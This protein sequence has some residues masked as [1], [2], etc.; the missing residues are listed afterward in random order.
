MNFTY[1]NQKNKLSTY[2]HVT[3]WCVL[4]FFLANFG[5]SEPVP[6]NTLLPGQST[7]TMIISGLGTTVPGGSP[8]PGTQYSY[9]TGESIF[10]MAN[11]TSN[12]WAFD[13]WS[14]DIGTWN[15]TDQFIRGLVM[16]QDRTVT[17]YFV[18]ADWTMTIQLSGNGTTSPPQGAYGFVDGFLAEA[19]AYPKPGGDAFRQW[20]G[21]LFEGMDP[22]RFDIP[23]IPM[24][25]N[26]VLTAEF[27][28]GDYTLTVHEPTGNG[29]GTLYFSPGVYAFLAGYD[30]SIRAMPSSNSFW[31]G[32]IGDVNSLEMDTR[33]I[34]D[35]N[36]EITPVF[37]S[38]G[39]RLTVNHT[40]N[41]LTVP[42]GGIGYAAGLNPMIR[43]VQSSTGIFDHWSGDIPPGMDPLKPD[44]F[45]LMDQDRTLTANFITADWYVKIQLSGSGTTDPVPGRYWRQEGNVQTLTA[46][47]NENWLFYRWSGTLPQEVDPTNPAIT[48]TIDRNLVLTAVFVTKHIA[49]PGLTGLSLQSAQTELDTA[50]LTQGA[51][52]YTYNPAAPAGQ[53]LQQSPVSGTVVEFGTKVDLVVSSGTRCLC[54]WHSADQNHDNQV[55]LSELLRVIQLYNSSEYHCAS[56]SEDGFAPGPGPKECLPHKG[57]YTPQ[58]WILSLS[59]LLRMA[60]LYSANTYHTQCDSEDGFSIESASADSC[61]GSIEGGD[62]SEGEG[63]EETYTLMLPGNIPLEMLW[64]PPGSFIM[65]RD[66]DEQDSNSDEDPPRRV[67]ISQGFWLGKYEV[68]QIQWQAVNGDHISRFSGNNRPVDMVSWNDTQSF[69]FTLNS[70]NPGMRFRLPSEAE[71]EYACRAGTSTRFHWGDD[72]DYTSISEYAWWSENSDAQTHAVGTKRPN[73]WGLFDMN[74]NVW[75]WCQ[76][77]YHLNYMGAPSDQRAWVIPTDW[78]RVTRGGSFYDRSGCRSAS[79][80]CDY[81]RWSNDH[82]TGFRIAR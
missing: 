1:T 8:A 74:G 70:L 34:M 69:L 62:T 11:Y 73:P 3:L 63:Q 57:D 29:T 27:G 32:W 28:P 13:H 82:G 66:S 39:Y 67:T 4:V 77:W 24:D 16:D 54:A 76:D 7:L 14:G 61:E 33:F 21:D 55:G 17:A 12:G 80:I 37:V 79:R 59:E 6:L 25:R 81:P 19:I 43:A 30:I 31:G 75:E 71:W 23:P 9:T 26:R 60:Q 15:P 51:F 22:Q 72:P 68:T 52:T 50:G 20:T 49:V 58:D 44:A 36:K 40:G 45:V 64:I 42:D 53:V 5:W 35:A 46:T 65:G 38:S 78:R 18:P 41:G 2:M 56:G 48:L 47:P 10:V